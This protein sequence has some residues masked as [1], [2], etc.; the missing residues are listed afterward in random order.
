MHVVCI[1]T[2]LSCLISGASAV[3]LIPREMKTRLLS[4]SL[5]LVPRPRPAFHHFA[6]LLATE[7][8]AGPGNKATVYSRTALSTLDGHPQ[9]KQI[10]ATWIFSPLANTKPASPILHRLTRLA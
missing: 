5:S 4:S 1:R 3:S 9:V 8:W 7:S 2:H 10:R 6:V